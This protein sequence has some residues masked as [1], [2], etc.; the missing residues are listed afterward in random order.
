[1]QSAAQ[2][3]T[4]KQYLRRRAYI[5]PVAPSTTPTWNL[6]EIKGLALANFGPGIEDTVITSSGGDVGQLAGQFKCD[7]LLVV[8]ACEDLLLELDPDSTP[9]PPAS[10][11][12]WIVD[13][14]GTTVGT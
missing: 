13:R 11:F 14:S 5:A 8:Q 1:M 9:L 2:Y 7:P 10:N 6:N 12:G 3:E 4:I